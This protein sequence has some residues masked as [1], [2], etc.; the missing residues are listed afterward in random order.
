MGATLGVEFLAA[1]GLNE[2][3]P[4]DALVAFAGVAPAHRDS[5]KVSGGLHRPVTYHRRLQRVFYISA[6]ISARYDHNWRKFCDCK[7]T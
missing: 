4:S 7:R 6:L 1:G 3:A 5:G 2:F